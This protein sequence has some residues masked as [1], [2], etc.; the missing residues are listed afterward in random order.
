MEIL[1]C[2]TLRGV[3]IFPHPR[4]NHSNDEALIECIIDIVNSKKQ[5]TE[6]KPNKLN[7]RKGNYLKINEYLKRIDW[8]TL[9][10]DKDM[11]EIYSIFVDTCL[12]TART[13][14]PEYRVNTYKSKKLW[15]NN[16]IWSAIKLKRKEWNRLKNSGWKSDDKWEAYKSARN[17][18]NKKVKRAMTSYERSITTKIKSDPRLVYSYIN[19]KKGIRNGIKSLRLADGTTESDPEIIANEFNR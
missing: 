9:F 11:N 17:R 16:E 5:R 3:I 8:V 10:H 19:K 14:I 13:F 7:Y 4:L 15:M 18:A 6:F 1:I 2:Q 12:T